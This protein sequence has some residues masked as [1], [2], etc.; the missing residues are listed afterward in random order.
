VSGAFSPVERAVLAYTD[1]L[2]LA[3]GR[4]AD[5]VVEVAAPDTFEARDLAVD[6]A[7]RPAHGDGEG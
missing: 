4:I 2:A 3:G 1:G 5:G 7:G 6:L